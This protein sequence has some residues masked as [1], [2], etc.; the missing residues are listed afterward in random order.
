MQNAAKKGRA[1]SK[2]YSTVYDALSHTKGKRHFFFF[3]AVQIIL[4]EHST[5]YYPFIY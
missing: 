3:F 2:P 4:R 1:I 5:Y